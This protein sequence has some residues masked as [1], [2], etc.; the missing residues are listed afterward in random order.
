MGGLADGVAM[1]A[2]QSAHCPAGAWRRSWAQTDK[3]CTWPRRCTQLLRRQDALQRTRAS[4]WPGQR[5]KQHQGSRPW[6]LACGRVRPLPP[7]P[8]A[9]P[10]AARE[11]AARGCRPRPPPPRR[12]TLPP[13]TAQGRPRCRHYA[14]TAPVRCA[15]PHALSRRGRARAGPLTWRTI[16]G[17]PRTWRWSAGTLPGARCAGRAMQGVRSTPKHAPDS[18]WPPP[19]KRRRLRARSLSSAASNYPP[20]RAARSRSRSTC[21]LWAVVPQAWP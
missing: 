14:Q 17:R 7:L 16:A 1:L 9:A 18:A 19:R 3:A 4:F 6:R 10:E 21:W 2:S 15:R 13:R 11:A 8:P 12:T 20:S 5:A